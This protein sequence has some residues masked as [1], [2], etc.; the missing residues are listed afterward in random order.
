MMYTIMPMD[1]VLASGEALKY[2]FEE[3]NINGQ[4]VQVTKGDDENYSVVRVMSTDPKTFLKPEF[5][6]GYRV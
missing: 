1:M 4:L 3:R 6:P 5:Q 2:N